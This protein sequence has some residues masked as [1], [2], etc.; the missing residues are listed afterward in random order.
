MS[1][2]ANKTN[3]K[4]QSSFILDFL[5]GGVAGAIGKTSTAPLERAKLLL[6]SQHTMSSLQVKYSGLTDCLSTLVRNEGFMALWRGNTINVVRYFP[7]QALS[8][9]LKDT[10]KNIFPKFNSE[11][12][13]YKF[14]F[15]N[16]LSGGLAGAISLLILH[17]IDAVR[18]RLATDNKV[19][20][21]HRKFNGTI[22]CLQKCYKY[23]GGIRGIYPGLMV[24][25]VGIFQ[26]RALYFGGYDTFKGRFMT[27]KNNF[28]QKWFAAQIIT[29]IAGFCCYPLDTVK[30]RIIVQSGEK[31][32]LYRNSFHCFS[33]MYKEEGIR[34]YFKGFSANLIRNLGSSLVLIL[35]D[36]FQK[37]AGVTARGV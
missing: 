27:E 36:E 4:K 5:L 21:G 18:T 30:R 11:T 10:F 25:I 16:C 6:Q 32:K 26:Y 34:G 22:D 31:H 7:N 14:F 28:F 35:Y 9:A 8:F 20:D 2:N 19:K 23:E 29:I 1:S 17:P 3:D 13:F 37:I 12:N 33:L 24:S 15:I